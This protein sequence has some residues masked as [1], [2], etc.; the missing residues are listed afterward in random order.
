MCA[1]RLRDARRRRAGRA[2]SVLAGRASPAARII[3]GVALP[4]DGGL[5]AA[6]NRVMAQELTLDTF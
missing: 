6:G 2:V 1:R 5:L 4:V 3:T